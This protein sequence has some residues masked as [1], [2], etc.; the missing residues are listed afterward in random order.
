MGLFGKKEAK[1]ECCCGGNCN[2]ETMEQAKNAQAGGAS[3]KILGG[4]CSKCHEL[5][6]NTQE[7]LEE[8]CINAEIEMVTD[9]TQIA[10][11][12]IMTTP[13][14]V[15]EGR[16]AAYG[17]VLKKDEIIKLIQDAAE[18]A[19]QNGSPFPWGGTDQK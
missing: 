18:K 1:K 2:A 4:G 15:I 13:A 14:L 11:Y 5:Q 6:K 8:L 3:F 7:A 10:A 12:G 19:S 9:F 16:V 17:K